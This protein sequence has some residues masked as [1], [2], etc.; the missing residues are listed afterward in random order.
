MVPMLGGSSSSHGPEHARAC[1]NKLHHTGY[2]HLS[3]LSMQ[4]FRHLEYILSDFSLGAMYINGFTKSETFW[5]ILANK[6]WYIL[7][8]KKER[9]NLMRRWALYQGKDEVA[10]H[11]IKLWV[12]CFWYIQDLASIEFYRFFSSST[13]NCSS[14]L[15]TP[16][17]WFCALLCESEDI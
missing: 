3:N 5:T 17:A 8:R 4:S 9:T 10:Q 15:C 2:S 1:S 12:M 7:L 6:I 13:V 14:T 11:L 16:T